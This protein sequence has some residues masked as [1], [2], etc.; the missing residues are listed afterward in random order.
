LTKAVASVVA[1]RA[2]AVCQQK[3]KGERERQKRKNLLRTK[4]T[5]LTAELGKKPKETEQ[6][7][8]IE[9]EL[10]NYKAELE[11]SELWS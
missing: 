1:I 6:V 7:A 8:K 4:I 10:A 3:R 5:Q 2:G 11:G 9:E